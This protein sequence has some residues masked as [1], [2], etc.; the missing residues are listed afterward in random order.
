MMFSP[1]GGTAKRPAKA[2]I[3]P[4]VKT[5][6]L[7]DFATKRHTSVRLARTENFRRH[8]DLYDEDGNLTDKLFETVVISEGVRSTD[9]RR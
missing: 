6:G 5:S 9:V 8:L 2:V 1:V 7:R 4:F 3:S